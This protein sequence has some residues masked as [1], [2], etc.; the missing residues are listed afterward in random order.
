MRKNFLRILIIAIFSAICLIGCT[1]KEDTSNLQLDNDST[2]VKDELDVLV[3]INETSDVEE[4][5]VGEDDVT[6][7]EPVKYNCKEEITAASPDSGLFQIDDM[8]FQYGE[9]LS[10]FLA[11]ID[12]SECTYTAEYNKNQLVP[13]GESEQIVFCK[14]GE[15]YFSIHASNYENETIELK[16]CVVDIICARKASK[17]NIYYAGSANETITYTSIKNTLDNYE[18]EREYTGYDSRQNKSLAILY[19]IPDLKD[20]AKGDGLFLY[21]KGENLYLYFIIDTHF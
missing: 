2:I 12:K 18:P 21:E 6:I 4:N 14:K 20:V 5:P 10:E 19:K 1:N 15:D 7:V 9:K 8:I 3:N 17:G 11:I 13:A 16:D